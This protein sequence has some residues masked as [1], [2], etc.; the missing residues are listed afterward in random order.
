[1]RK[2]AGS[3]GLDQGAVKAIRVGKKSLLASGIT[4]IAG[5]FDMG[6]IVEMTADDGSKVGK[7]IV[8]YSSAELKLIIGKKS[9]EIKKT[10]GS[11]YYEEVINRDELIVY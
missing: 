5:A 6:D 8:N 2:P 4:G 1:M 9:P 3:V 7:G 10:L 11:N